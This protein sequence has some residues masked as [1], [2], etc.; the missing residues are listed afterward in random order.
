M[1]I[2]FSAFLIWIA[3]VFDIIHSEDYWGYIFLCGVTEMIIHVI[4][5]V[6]QKIMY[7]RDLDYG[8]SWELMK[9]FNKINN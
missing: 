6:V 3:S 9:F 7:K 1:H 8:G 5:I 2:C 4:I